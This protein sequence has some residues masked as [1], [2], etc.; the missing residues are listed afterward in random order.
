MEW[1]MKYILCKHLHKKE[2]DEKRET[3]F[4][5]KNEKHRLLA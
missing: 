5:E 3:N 4:S 2:H 1:Y